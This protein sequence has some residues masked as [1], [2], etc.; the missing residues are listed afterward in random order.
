MLIH[1][2]SI[3]PEPEGSPIHIDMAAGPEGSIRSAP[4]GRTAGSLHL[5]V[6]V[7]VVSG[8]DEDQVRIDEP[9]ASF[10]AARN[11]E[12]VE[13]RVGAEPQGSV[14]VAHAHGLDVGVGGAGTERGG[15]HFGARHAVA[16]VQGRREVHDVAHHD[17]LALGHGPFA[18]ARDGDGSLRIRGER[19]RVAGGQHLH[20]GAQFGG[21]ELGHG[22]AGGGAGH[23]LSG[24][25]TVAAQVRGGGDGRGQVAVG[26]H[27]EVPD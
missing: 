27:A 25:R 19:R 10:V 20:L 3:S 7:R 2:F 22:V 18:E 9:V 1:A 16:V 6:G 14:D 13:G 4:S 23:L 15:D 12:R 24:Q 8:G 21:D 5:G 26:S 11:V 17:L